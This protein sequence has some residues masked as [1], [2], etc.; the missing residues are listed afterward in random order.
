M[1]NVAQPA[2][3][4]ITYY[5]RDSHGD[6]HPSSRRQGEQVSEADARRVGARWLAASAVRP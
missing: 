3:G 2:T 6:V 4:E 5:S 1:M